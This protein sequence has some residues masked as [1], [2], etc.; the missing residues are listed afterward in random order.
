[1]LKPCAYREALVEGY[2]NEA[3]HFPRA[4]VVPYPGDHLRRGGVAKVKVLDESEDAKRTRQFLG[5][6]V[7]SFCYVSEERS[8]PQGGD[9][10]P[11]PLP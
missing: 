11:V 5:I 10:L 8:V 2:P 1:M 6:F 7:S 4:C 3:A 9:G